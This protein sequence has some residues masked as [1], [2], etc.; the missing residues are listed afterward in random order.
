[1]TLAVIWHVEVT[2]PP[3]QRPGNDYHS[4]QMRR[5]V[6]MN[7]KDSQFHLDIGLALFVA[8]EL[9]HRWLQCEKR[10]S[11][12][13]GNQ[14]KGIEELDRLGYHMFHCIYRQVPD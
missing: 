5:V 13:L 6:L 8:A 4:H 10:D 1:M 9:R 2:S 7:G 12:V 14:V 3:A 11:Q